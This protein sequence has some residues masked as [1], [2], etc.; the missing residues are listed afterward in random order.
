MLRLPPLKPFVFS[1]ASLLLHDNEL[2]PP[3]CSQPPT[4]LLQSCYK[5]ITTYLSSSSIFQNRIRDT[6]YLL[7]NIGPDD[8]TETTYH[9][10]H[11]EA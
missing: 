4:W 5:L 2:L 3:S 9:F 11:D 10:G 1:R 7:F 8:L 6:N